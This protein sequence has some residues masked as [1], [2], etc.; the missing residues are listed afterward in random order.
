MRSWK[1][2]RVNMSDDLQTYT[3]LRC[4]HTLAHLHAASWW[5]LTIFDRLQTHWEM[6]LFQ[7]AQQQWSCPPRK[8]PSWMRV[9]WTCRSRLAEGE[10]KR[11]EGSVSAYIC[12]FMLECIYGKCVSESVC[13][14][15]S[16]QG[17]NWEA[18]L[19]TVQHPT[20]PWEDTIEKSQQCQEGN[21]VDN[22]VGH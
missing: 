4:S 3:A 18:E 5:I 6:S 7:S 22:N 2:K 16:G 13:A 21:Q 10:K 17:L 15:V 14:C 12:G 8:H 20:Q 9:A 1:K 11:S 19:W